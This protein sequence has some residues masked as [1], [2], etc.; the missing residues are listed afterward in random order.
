MDIKLQVENEYVPE[1]FGNNKK[2]GNEQ[3]IIT[4]RYPTPS[5]R[6]LFRPQHVDMNGKLTTKLDYDQ[7]ISTCVTKIEN[8]KLNGVAVKT[9][10]ELN[11]SPGL[12]ALA[13]EMKNLLLNKMFEINSKNF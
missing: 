7:I 6:N 11:K 2:S 4:W 1:A 12:T 5:E 3:I 13:E 10:R 9:G 8:L